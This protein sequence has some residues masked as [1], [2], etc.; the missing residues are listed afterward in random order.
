MADL[1]IIIPAFNE[2]KKIAADIEAAGKFL[3][4]NNLNG[5]IIVVDDGSF[6]DT[7]EAAKKACTNLPTK[8]EVKVERY[9]RRRGKGCA[10]R[11]GIEQS[12][13]QYVMFA[14]SGLCVPYENILLGLDLIKAGRCEIAHGSRKMQAS[15]IK[16]AQSFY[17]K[18]CS[19]IFHFFVIHFL[20]IPS[21]LTDTQC[22]FKI[23]K[24]DIARSLY[25]ECI[26]SGFMFDIEIILRALKKGCLIKEFPI[27]WT[28]DPDTRLS[29]SRSLWRII[30]ELIALKRALKKQ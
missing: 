12:T 26:S 5:Q 20:K 29:P 30:A 13:G 8:V 4:C 10:I 9:Y 15:D 7:S 17:R 19:A 24:G 14:D 6:D 21:G 23:Y 16:K 18:L 25:R 2:G 27:Q 3:E 22:G 28:C 11:T 1:S